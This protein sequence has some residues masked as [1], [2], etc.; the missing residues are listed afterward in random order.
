[1]MGMTISNMS[2]AS[3]H[4]HQPRFRTGQHAGVSGELGATDQDC[5]STVRPPIPWWAS[6]ATRALMTS[7]VFG[8]PSLMTFKA[9]SLFSH[10]LYFFIERVHFLVVPLV[11]RFRRLATA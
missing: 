8:R 2:S 4:V 11:L 9:Q 6:S 7:T 1:M 10:A 5:C 3:S